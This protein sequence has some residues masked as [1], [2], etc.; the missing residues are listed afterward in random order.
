MSSYLM[1]FASY[2]QEGIQNPVMISDKEVR[3]FEALMKSPRI[4]DDE[5][6]DMLVSIYDKYKPLIDKVLSK[7]Q[8]E[9]KKQIRGMAKVKFMSNSKPFESIRDKAL[10]RGKGFMGLNDLVRGAVLFDTKEQAD[11]FVKDFTRKNSAK[12]VEYEEKEKGG[13][14]EY[15]YYGSHHIGMN[16]DGLIVE[17]QVMT[18]KLWNYKHEAHKLYK[19]SRSRKGGATKG[20]KVRSKNIF[21]LGNRPGYVKD[22]WNIDDW[23]VILETDEYGDEI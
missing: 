14:T 16:I 3:K 6:L 2:L 22:D 11:K 20:E 19:A 4:S 23:D 10:A 13:D 5:K 9:V 15:G 7:F 12:V 21:S 17:I 18:R 8:N 1:S